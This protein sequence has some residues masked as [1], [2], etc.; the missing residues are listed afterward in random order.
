L[1]LI[2]VILILTRGMKEEG[3]GAG[4]YSPELMQL[5]GGAGGYQ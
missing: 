2:A 4:M 3:E 1:I 5:L